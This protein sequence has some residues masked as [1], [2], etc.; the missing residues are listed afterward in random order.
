MHADDDAINPANL[1]R[2]GTLFN[3]FKNG[4]FSRGGFS[5]ILSTAS[6]GLSNFIFHMLISR[7][8]MPSEYS[9]TNSLLSFLAFLAVPIGA[10]QLIATQSVAH[11]MKFKSNYSITRLIKSSLF[12]G[13]LT[14]LLLLIWADQFDRFLQIQSK[15]PIFFVAMWIPIATLGSVCI[16]ALIGEFQFNKTAVISFIGSITRVLIF[17]VLVLTGTRGIGGVLATLLS[18]LLITGW[19]FFLLRKKIFQNNNLIE[20][21]ADANKLFISITALSGL[22]ALVSIDTFLT[23]HLFSAQEAGIYSAAA[24]ASHLVFFLPGS[25]MIVVF[26]HLSFDVKLKSSG[27]KIFYQAITLTALLEIPLVGLLYLYP[28]QVIRLIFGKNYSTGAQYLG[29][30]AIMSA[31]FGILGIYVYFQIAQKSWISLSSWIG[32][33]VALILIKF[34]PHN[35]KQ[36]S[37]I[38]L[39]ATTV[40]AALVIIPSQIL[41]RRSRKKLSSVLLPVELSNEART[42]L[43]IVVPYY[44]PGSSVSA[45]IVEIAKTLESEGLSYEVIAISDGSTDESPWLLTNLQINNFRNIVNEM[46]QGKGAVLRIGLSMGSGRYIGFIDGDGDIPASTLSIFI[47]EIR[48]QKPDILYGSKRCP[49]SNVIYPPIRKIYSYGYQLLIK[50]LFNL[51]VRDTQTGLK[52]YRRELLVKALPMMLEKRF[53]FDLELFVIAQKLGHGVYVELPVTIKERFTSSISIV[54]V[55]NILWDTLAIFYRANILRHYDLIPE[56]DLE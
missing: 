18:Q 43:T 49:E 7:M 25:L 42:D 56:S 10:I 30:L 13:I 21:E 24:L 28:N 27:L 38:M 55:R 32:V 35:P 22:T 47:D 14:S 19:A 8:L 37:I 45:H 31:V 23:R 12:I 48:K 50:I 4:I 36:L 34:Q 15:L 26:P 5:L 17:V 16:G 2:L 11:S 53:A 44:N 1:H 41:I 51:P 52:I 54:S 33:L 39:I 46:N 29:I 3:S 9:L 6:A 20:I 40:S